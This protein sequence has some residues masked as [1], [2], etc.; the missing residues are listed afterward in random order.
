M[1]ATIFQINN[2]FANEK[3]INLHKLFT[4]TEKFR[5]YDFS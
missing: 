1:L 4:F 3:Q 2:D 5:V